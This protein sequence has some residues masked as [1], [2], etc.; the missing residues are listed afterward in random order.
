MYVGLDIHKKH[1]QACVMDESGRIVQELKFLNE[2]DELAKFL[3]SI[4]KGSKIAM[5]ACSLWMAIYEE[6]E[7]KGFDVHL[8]HPSKVR[9]IAE[10]KIKTDRIDAKVLAHLMR[11]DMLPEAYIAPEHVR[12]L[13]NIARHRYSLVRLRASVKHR[14][15]SILHKVG[16]E[17]ELTDIF[18]KGGMKFLQE[19]PLKPEHRFA[20]NHYLGMIRM[21]NIMIGETDRYIDVQSMRIPEVQLLR[22]IPGIGAYSALLIY[23]EIGDISR[24]PHYKHL[25]SYA[26]LTASVHQSGSTV[27]YGHITKQGDSLLRW[28]IVQAVLKTKRRS[29]G[30]Q[31]FH[32]RLVAKKGKKVAKIALAR[33]MLVYIHVMLTHNVRFDELRVNS[34]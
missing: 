29:P 23:A 34:V 17:I 30:M 27:R 11:T 1:N 25:C 32:K 33:K 13:R 10:A 9:L 14:A 20:L 7:E 31:R 5:E 16:I 8:A 12:K 26:G 28:I 4:P 15:H 18:G 6:I 2:K 3:E 22:S 19:V 24:F 21:L